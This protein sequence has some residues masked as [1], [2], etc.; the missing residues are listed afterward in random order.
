MYKVC[1]L[2]P[3]L[4]NKATLI[5]EN[6][7]CFMKYKDIQKFQNKPILFLLTPIRKFWS[8][9]WFGS[10]YTKQKHLPSFVQKI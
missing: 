2:V 10:I 8:I 3:I 5:S 9:F 1:Q 7:I 4:Q 6:K